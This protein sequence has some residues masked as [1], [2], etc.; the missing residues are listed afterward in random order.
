MCYDVVDD[1]D[2]DDDH[3]ELSGNQRTERHLLLYRAV[4]FTCIEI[5][6]VLARA[7]LT[8]IKIYT[9]HTS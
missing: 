5:D 8:C 2:Y 9:H 6:C 1:D 4:S 7:D 3:N